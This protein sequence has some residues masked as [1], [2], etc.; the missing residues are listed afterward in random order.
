VASRVGALD[1]LVA[2]GATGLLCPP[3]DPVALAG[4]L[5]EL[6]GDPA[7]CAR[8]GAAGRSRVLAEHTWDAVVDRVLALAGVDIP[9]VPDGP[10]PPAIPV[11]AFGTAG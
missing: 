6:A 11:R 5:A 10:G 9:A 1:D 8:M 4:A 3:G 2:H 7:R